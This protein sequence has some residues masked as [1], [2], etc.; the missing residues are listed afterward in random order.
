[1]DSI[2]ITV[3]LGTGAAEYDMEVSPNVPCGE[4]AAQVAQAIRV[5]DFAAA[6]R[7]GANPYLATADGR[8]LPDETTLGRMGL[9]DGSII[10]L[11]SDNA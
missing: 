11:G 3:R 9:W 2:V 6:Q 1:M 7:L 4:L 8:R 5:K 10:V